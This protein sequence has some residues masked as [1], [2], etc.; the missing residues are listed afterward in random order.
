MQHMRN[1]VQ[2]LIYWTIWRRLLSVRPVRTPL[3]ARMVSVRFW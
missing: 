1:T 3:W 2:G